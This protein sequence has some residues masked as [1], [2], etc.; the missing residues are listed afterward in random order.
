MSTVLKDAFSVTRLSFWT[1]ALLSS[2]IGSALYIFTQRSIESDAQERFVNH[3]RYA[4]SVIGV[5]IKSYTDL[6]RGAGSMIQSVDTFD[7]RQFHDYV[8]GLELPRN[9]PAVDFM[10]YAV[11]VPES[12][13]EAFLAGLDREIRTMLGPTASVRIAPPGIRPAYLVVA[14]IEP[15]APADTFYGVD[16]MANRYFGN[17]LLQA[18]DDGKL[19][20]AGT[21]IPV[22]SRPNECYLGLRMPTYRRGMPLDTVERRRA[23]YTGSIGIAFSL[24]KL[25]HGVLDEIPIPGVRMTLYDTGPRM[26]VHGRDS[27]GRPLTLFDSR[28]TPAHPTPPLDTGRAMYVVTLSLDF[29]GRPW[30]TTY[31]V[32]KAALYTEFDDYYP[33]LM[34]LFGFIGAILLY[35]LLQMLTSSRRAALELAQEMTS[36]LRESQSKLQLS[37]QKLRRLADHAYQ[38][39][40]LERKRIAREIHDD[41]GQNLLA[42]R[43]E[44]ELLATR[45]RGSHNILHRRARATLLQI[46]TTIKSVRQIIN[47]LRPTVLDLGLSAAVEWQVNQFQRRTG[48]RCRI[49]DDHGEI[50][51]PDH[52]A[53]AFFRIL[54]ESLTNIVRHAHASEVVVALRLEGNWLSLSVRDNG[55]GLPPGGRNK[56]GSFGLVGIEERIVILGGTCAVFSEPDGG[57]TV[58]VSAPVIG[59]P[60][61]NPYPEDEMQPGS[62]VI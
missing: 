12:G 10:N 11:Y 17:Q 21:P 1:G 26:D 59:T 43:I 51:L 50:A 4:Q 2:L 54:Q 18:R 45:T 39:K 13:R 25:L 32:P 42:L 44:T 20:A 33:K 29:N 16:L 60:P 3:A 35:A 9:F 48:I 30:K 14:H 31:S 28:G 56:Y 6:L 34:M 15:D 40:E 55:C 19:H 24:P 53:T 38:I 23:A 58:M 62:A 7:H 36:E 41:L 49:E 52:C 22:L 37:H 57:T 61:P 46:D 5:R 8:R 47:D 27:S